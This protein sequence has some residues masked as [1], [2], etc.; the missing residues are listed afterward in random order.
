MANN[1]KKRGNR[2]RKAKKN[3]G[4]RDNLKSVQM[5][6][7][8]MRPDTV[9]VGNV[10]RNM[11]VKSKL[12]MLKTMCNP[13]N[14]ASLGCKYPDGQVGYTIPIQ[15][16]GMNIPPTLAGGNGFYCFGTG[17]PCNYIQAFQYTAPNYDLQVN[18]SA[19]YINNTLGAM[20]TN[21]CTLRP[22]CGG[23]VIRCIQSAM[24]AQG[25]LIVSKFPE[26]IAANSQ[27]T[28]AGMYGEVKLYPITAGMEVCVLFKPTGVDAHKFSGLNTG[29][30]E[31]AYQWDYIGVE[32]VGASASTSVLEF[33]YIVNYEV[34]VN[35]ASQSYSAFAT[36]S[37]TDTVLTTA[38]RSIWTEASSIIEGGVEAAGRYLGRFAR[39]AVAGLIGG[40]EMGM[41]ALTV[42]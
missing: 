19:T 3:K 31:S 24:N 33:E 16:R 14:T 17:Y 13:F 15:V 34:A 12:E 7:K 21:G 29:T 20:I 27:Y 10:A 37:K 1:K 39:S 41:L 4:T 5:M 35:A 28:S 8:S 11:V 26:Y 36:K 30:T 9:R 22:V 2:A 25:T 38:T 40:P 18:W 42:D 6:T 23:I 32:V